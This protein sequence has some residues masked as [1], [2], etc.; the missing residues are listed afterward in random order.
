MGRTG[1]RS[2]RI[3]LSGASSS[4]RVARRLASVHGARRLRRQQRTG[5]CGLDRHVG[6]RRHGLGGTRPCATASQK[7]ALFGSLL[8]VLPTA[9]TC[10]WPTFP[11]MRTRFNPAGG[12]VDTDPYGIVALPGRRVVAD[13]GANALIESHGWLDCR[14]RDRT[15]AVLPRRAPDSRPCQPRLSKVPIAHPYVGGTHGALFLRGTSTIYRV[16]PRWRRR[17]CTWPA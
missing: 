13:A 9:H 14:G 10:R 4:E 1:A 17:R 11:R 2:P 12:P 3:D 16:P 15:L 6:V 7:G 5:R 8:R